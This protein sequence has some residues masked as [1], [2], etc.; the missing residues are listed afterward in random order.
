MDRLFRSELLRALDEGTPF[1]MGI[2]SRVK[3]SSPQ[4]LGAKAL[5]FRDGRIV[6]T[7]GGGCLEAEVRERARHSLVTGVPVRFELL[8]DHDFG[9]DDGLICGGKVEVLVLPHAPGASELWRKLAAREEAVNWG[10]GGDFEITGFNPGAP[11]GGEWLYQENVLP[12]VVLWLGGAGHVS[13]AVARQA[14][15]LDFAVTVF[16]DRPA[17]ANSSLFPP[18]CSLRVGPWEDLL[19]ESI[20]PRTVFGLVLTRGHNHDAL[21]LSRWI[22]QP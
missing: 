12:P 8:L 16:D 18:E 11:K 17:L 2:L 20:P 4:K 10:V 13:Q 5:F 14:A 21:V 1:A 9:W 6:G 15:L 7:M 3:G 19:A 22:R